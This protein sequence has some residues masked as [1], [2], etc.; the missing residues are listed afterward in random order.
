MLGP[1]RD[2]ETGSKI[3]SDPSRTH[4]RAHVGSC[5][6]VPPR[7]EEEAFGDLDPMGVLRARVWPPGRAMGQGFPPGC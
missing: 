2:G 6:V 3:H 4:F 5:A 7:L 1:R